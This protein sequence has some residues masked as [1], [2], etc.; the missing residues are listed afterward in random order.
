MCCLYSNQT[1][2]FN[3]EFSQQFYITVNNNSISWQYIVL[4]L[5]AVASNAIILAYI[6]SSRDNVSSMQ[7]CMQHAHILTQFGL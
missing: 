5:A 3:G 4:V 7:A 2:G 6:Y 1:D